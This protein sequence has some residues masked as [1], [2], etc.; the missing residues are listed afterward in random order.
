MKSLRVQCR[1]WCDGHETFNYL[2]V[3]ATLYVFLCAVTE[4]MKTNNT[5]FGASSNMH[6]FNRNNR[7]L[8]WQVGL[9]CPT[10]TVHC[11]MSGLLLII[12]S[13]LADS[14]SSVSRRKWC[15]P[16]S[17]RTASRELFITAQNK[18]VFID[19]VRLHCGRR[20]LFICSIHLCDVINLRHL[21][22]M[23]CI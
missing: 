15:E 9:W 4:G 14:C 10:A 22:R 20:L 12:C 8:W 3:S 1:V 6:A 18:I 2:N 17:S 7:K 13:T 21:R 16:M 11:K 19:G 23:L 5:H